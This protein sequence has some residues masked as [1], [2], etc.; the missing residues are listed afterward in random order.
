MIHLGIDIEKNR[1]YIGPFSDEWIERD[2][3]SC[4][5]RISHNF[6]LE[7]VE[8]KCDIDLL[9]SDPC[10]TYDGIF[11]IDSPDPTTTIKLFIARLCPKPSRIMF[12][13]YGKVIGEVDNIIPNL[14]YKEEGWYCS[15]M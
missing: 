2:R 1:I 15:I 12:Y 3:N 7:G 14:T 6:I 8:Y 13:Y 9:T 4:L 10:I 11:H 5:N